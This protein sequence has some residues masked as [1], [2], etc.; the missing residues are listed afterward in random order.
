MYPYLLISSACITENS[1][2]LSEPLL[3]EAGKLHFHF[4]NEHKEQVLES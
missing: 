3:K 2:L 4:L 1:F